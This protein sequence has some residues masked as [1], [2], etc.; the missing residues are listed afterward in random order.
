M[1]RILALTILL[2]SITTAAHADVIVPNGLAGVEG[3][4]DNGFPF[5]IAAFGLPSQ[6]YQQIYESAEFPGSYWITGMTFRPDANFGNPFA[7]VL[8][9]VQIDL[10]TTV[11]TPDTLSTSFG[12]N[13]GGDVTTVFSGALSLSSL[14]L[15]PVGGP[16]N[17]DIAIVFTTPFLYN[18]TL[19]DLLLDVRNFGGGSSTQFDA[20]SAGGDPISRMF[21]VGGG[22]GSATGVGDSAGLVTEF[23]VTAVPEPASLA[24]L[25]MGLL[26]I[27]RRLR[28][29]S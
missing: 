28:R 9:S 13:V 23:Q 20:H 21:S 16:K 11:K 27:G 3:N 1:K 12:A 8:P 10:S 4:F 14:D 22:V 18:P 2:G 19:G 15:G 17:F 24:L 5:N 6:R 29:Q 25:G 26:A 7:S